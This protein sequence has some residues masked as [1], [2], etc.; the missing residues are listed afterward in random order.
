MIFV[1]F[2][3]SIVSLAIA[4]DNYTSIKEIRYR[5]NKLYLNSVYGKSVC[6]EYADTDS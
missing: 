5:Y 6:E 4:L 3:V 2:I 1:T